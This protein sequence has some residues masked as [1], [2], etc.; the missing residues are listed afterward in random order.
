MLVIVRGMLSRMKAARLRRRLT[1]SELGKR[2]GL[3]AAEIG[4]LE[5]G[6]FFPAPRQATRLAR[7]LKLKPEQLLEPDDASDGVE[8]SPA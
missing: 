2:T 4:C 6:R 3:T 7:V 8:T 5:R 1:Q